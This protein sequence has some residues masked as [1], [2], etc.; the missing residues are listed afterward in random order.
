[1]CAPGANIWSRR[2][3]KTPSTPT[4]AFD[5][6]FRCPVILLICPPVP[7]RRS[8]SSCRLDERPPASLHILSLTAPQIEEKS[9]PDCSPALRSASAPPPPVPPQ[10]TEPF[11]G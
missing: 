7:A 9:R 1:M 5:K 4:S 6:R 2:S 11:P 8:L 10:S 3:P